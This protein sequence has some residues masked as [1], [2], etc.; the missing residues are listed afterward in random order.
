MNGG[1][2]GQAVFISAGANQMI[3][4]ISFIGNINNSYVA[5]FLRTTPKFFD[6]D[7]LKP[8][9]MPSVSV[10]NNPIEKKEASKD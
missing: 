3:R 8:D 9:N 6:L 10:N 5:Y 1:Q 7:F 2:L 4:F